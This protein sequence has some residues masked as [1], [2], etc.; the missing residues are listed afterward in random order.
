M[1]YNF[2]VFVLHK[3]MKFFSSLT[4][5]RVKIIMKR[6]PEA[7]S[8]RRAKHATGKSSVT[9]NKLRDVMAIAENEG[10][11]R[12]ERPQVVRGRMPRALVARAKKRA[13]IDSD[14]ELIEVAL[15]HIA[16]ADDYAEW[17]LSR[18]G[19]VDPE[20]DLEF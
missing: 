14:T 18:R 1:Y 16:V 20:I 19:T 9:P 11:L 5:L 7:G 8:S 15:A 6:V 4:Y 13:G 3:P 12:G 17:L 10:L 2:I